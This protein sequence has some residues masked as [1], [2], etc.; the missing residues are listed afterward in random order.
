MKSILG[1]GMLVAATALTTGCASKN[2]VSDA[3]LRAHPSPE[4]MS[5]SMRTDDVKFSLAYMRNINQRM[6]WDDVARW[7]YWDQPSRLSPY[8]IMDLNGQPR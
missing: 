8:P 5:T 6:F 4:L 3:A 7:A 1:I 2:S